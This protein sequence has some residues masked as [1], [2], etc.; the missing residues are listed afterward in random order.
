MKRYISLF[1]LVLLVAWLSSC[2]KGSSDSGP[3]M[4]GG[5]TAGKSGSM[6]KFN[7]SN[8]HLFLINEKDLIIYDISNS[9]NPIETSRLEV[10]FGIETVFTLHD[11][12]FIGA[13]NGVY[14]Y[15]IGNPA[16]ILY[17]SH[18]EHITSCDPVV[19]NDEFA[20]ATLNANSSCRWQTGA[21]VLDVINI[22]NIVYP[23]HVDS[24]FLDD[25][26]GLA[27]EGNYLFVCNGVSGLEIFDISNPY[28]LDKISGVA[29][30]HAY[31]VIL[32]NNVLILV[33]EDGLF[34]YNYD[35][36]YQL[37]LLSNILF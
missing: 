3:S 31:D 28:S 12:L 6:A 13:N 8:D 18:Y 35:N 10:D 23:Q 19:A 17:L 25:P 9:S 36:V 34:Q 2:Q 22:Q 14:I 27:L 16:N 15:D 29:G 20:F 4:P 1:G 7:I 5:E 24:Y 30:I 33:G 37:E 26:K 21:N 32:N 11:K